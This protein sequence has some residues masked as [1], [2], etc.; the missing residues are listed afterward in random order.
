MYHMLLFI[1]IRMDV[2]HQILMPS[3]LE[4]GQCIEIFA[5]VR[6]ELIFLCSFLLTLSN[7]F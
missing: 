7:G 4:Q 2:S 6:I 5:L 3:Y 1:I